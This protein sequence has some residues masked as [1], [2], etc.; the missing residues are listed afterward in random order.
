VWNPKQP[1]QL[2]ETQWYKIQNNKCFNILSL[3]YLFPSPT[4]GLIYSS[5]RTARTS[6]W[7]ALASQ[8]RR[9]L[10]RASCRSWAS[11]DQ[12]H[13]AAIT[14]WMEKLSK[15][16]VSLSLNVSNLNTTRKKE[17]LK[18]NCV[19]TRSLSLNVS[20]LNT[21]RKKEFHLVDHHYHNCKR[22]NLPS[23][24]SIIYC[25]CTHVFYKHPNLG[26][27]ICIWFHT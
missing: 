23:W 7:R 4:S 26:I 5:E 17:T 11:L 20:N 2:L 21:T 15:R 25:R 1:C 16:I 9:K 18:T 19:G 12:V 24:I 14:V 8:K 6:R 3:P 27:F 10:R 13:K 22:Y